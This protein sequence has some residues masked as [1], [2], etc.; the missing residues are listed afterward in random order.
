MKRFKFIVSCAVV[1]ALALTACDD[2]NFE[3]VPTESTTETVVTTET[4]EAEV[5][6]AISG[7]PSVTATPAPSGTTVTTTTVPG[8][9]ETEETENNGSSGSENSGSGSSGDTSSGGGSNGGDTSSG[10]SSGGSSSGSGESSGGSSS[11]G[12]SSGGSSSNT[13]PTPEP[14]ATSVPKP[15]ETTSTQ[16]AR[17]ACGSCGQQKLVDT[18]N[19]HYTTPEK[20]HEETTETWDYGIQHCEVQINWNGNA[21]ALGDPPSIKVAFDRKV[22]TSGKPYD[23]SAEEQATVKANEKA[24]EW[25]KS[26]GIESGFGG[27]FSWQTNKGSTDKINYNKTTITVVDEPAHE[28]EVGAYVCDNCGAVTIYGT[29]KQIK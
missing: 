9:T 23:N 11:G 22:D 7:T 21:K 24:D 12:S 13:T 26:M 5:T 20:T 4:D 28:Y 17:R 15:T 1:M 25:L 10:S 18:P 8:E 2:T 16:Y 29:P 3:L 27:Y 19:Y 14:V 6:P